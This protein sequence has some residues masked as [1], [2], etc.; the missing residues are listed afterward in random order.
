MN[1]VHYVRV[2]TTSS[3]EMHEEGKRGLK[4][5]NA[6]YHSVQNLLSASLL[7]RNMKISFVWVWNLVAHN[8]RGTYA[9]CVLR[10]MFGSRRDDVTGE[11][12]ILHNEEL[13]DL[14]C[15]ENII[16]MI[17]SRRMRLVGHVACTGDRESAYRDLT[18]RPERK[19]SYGRPRLSWEDNIK[20]VLQEM[21]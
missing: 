4:S 10:R 11:W 16:R 19:K 1:K 21:W 18:G 14:Y 9:E 8:E 6:Y 20:V 5:G 13:Y 15:S 3:D 7:Q 12:R 17:K 2:T